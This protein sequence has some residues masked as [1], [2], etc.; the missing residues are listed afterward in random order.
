MEPWVYA[1]IFIVAI[2]SF[3][4]ADKQVWGLMRQKHT[5]AF[6]KG[7]DKKE[8]VKRRL[9]IMPEYIGVLILSTLATMLLFPLLIIDGAIWLFKKIKGAVKHE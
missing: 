8:R 6:E 9:K 2:I 7:L 5:T 4:Y 1:I 3:W